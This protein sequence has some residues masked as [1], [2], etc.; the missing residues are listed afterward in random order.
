MAAK[1]VITLVL[2]TRTDFEML[3]EDGILMRMEAAEHE[4]ISVFFNK[5]LDCIK[6]V[7]GYE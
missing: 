3:K 5:E 7:N 6:L 2:A 1:S 4:D